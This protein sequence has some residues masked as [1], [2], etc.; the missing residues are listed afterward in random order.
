VLRLWRLA[1]ISEELVLGATERM[2][3]LEQH[4]QDLENE[5]RHLKAQLNLGSPGEL[6]R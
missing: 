4:L 2:D 5:N 1:K 6:V 3:L